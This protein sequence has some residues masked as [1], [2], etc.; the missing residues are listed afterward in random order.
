M[1]I[2]HQQIAADINALARYLALDDFGGAPPA[3]GDLR[4]VGVVALFGNQVVATLARACELAQIATH[5]TLLFSGGIGHSTRLLYENLD[6]DPHIK[7]QGVLYPEMPEAEMY[8]AFAQ[9]VFSIPAGRILVENRSRNAGE[10]AR[11]SIGTLNDAALAGQTV[12]LLQDPSM[13]RRAILTWQREAELADAKGQLL[14]HSAFVPFVEAATD[15]TFRLRHGQAT[16]SWSFARLTALL[17]GEIRR[18]RD[19]ENG[20]GPHGQNFIAHV[21]IPEP[22]LESYGRLAASVFIQNPDQS[23]QSRR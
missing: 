11:F 20:Y 13:Q 1:S 2:S 8:A 15:G 19:D 14:S 3:S 9:S 18:L 7:A 6:A 4:S 12:L 10:N 16:G 22:V 21:D 5:T 23:S 17:M